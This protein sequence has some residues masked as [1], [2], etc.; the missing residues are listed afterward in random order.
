MTV[1]Q[2]Y[3]LYK[4]QKSIEEPLDGC[5]EIIVKQ[6]K[7]SEHLKDNKTK[8][9][10]NT[11]ALKKSETKNTLNRLEQSSRTNNDIK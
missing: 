1:K 4:E 7:K 11:W 6:R 5:L 10:I 8:H 3:I 2:S 9:V